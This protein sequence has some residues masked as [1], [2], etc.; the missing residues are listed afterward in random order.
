MYDKVLEFH[1]AFNLAVNQAPSEGLLRLRMK[2][3][4]EEYNEVR[5]ELSRESLDLERTTA[6]LADLMYVVLGT[7]ISLGLP[8]VEVFDEIHRANMS[9]LGSDGKPIYREDGKVLKGPYYQPASL[10]KFFKEMN[11]IE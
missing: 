7:A 6:E 4:E 9:K 5:D 10:T 2:L 1:K 11:R 8:I 3:I